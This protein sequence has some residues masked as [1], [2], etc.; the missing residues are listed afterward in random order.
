[1]AGQLLPSLTV[2]PYDFRQLRQILIERGGKDMDP[3]ALDMCARHTVRNSGDIRSC[4]H[5]CDQ[6]IQQARKHQKRASIKDV[7]SMIN[8][9]STQVKPEIEKVA[10]ICQLN[11]HQKIVLDLLSKHRNEEEKE[12]IPSSQLFMRFNS[13]PWIRKLRLS[14]IPY[15]MFLDVL[16]G[17]ESHDV[18]EMKPHLKR[19]FYNASGTGKLVYL[20]VSGDQVEKGIQSLKHEMDQVI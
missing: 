5:L 18:I 11:I 10:I 8:Q 6:V 4:F 16:N 1:M 9:K 7:V 14:A 2:A 3:A 17:L 13:S 15:N 19:G 20:R 12:R